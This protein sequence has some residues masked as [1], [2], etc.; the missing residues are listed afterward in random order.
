MPTGFR[1]IRWNTFMIIATGI[2]TAGSIWVLSAKG[3]PGTIGLIILG[4][5][6]LLGTF[7]FMKK[8]RV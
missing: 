6:A 3:L 8:N 5:L 7:G 1:R 2:A 4:S